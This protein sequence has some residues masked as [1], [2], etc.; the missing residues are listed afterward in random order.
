MNRTITQLVILA[1]TFADELEAIL[2]SSA[3]PEA[4]ASPEPPKPRG[5]PKKEQAAAEPEPPKEEKKEEPATPT[6]KT[7][8]E[9]K[10]LIKPA[11]EAGA[12]AEVKKVIVKHGGSQLSDIPAANHAAFEADIAALVY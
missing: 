2:Q 7:L 5:R 6:G 9:L 4:A 3:S 11:V 8:D 12:G 1:R 10:A